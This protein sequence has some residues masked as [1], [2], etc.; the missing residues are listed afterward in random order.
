MADCLAVKNFVRLRCEK[1]SLWREFQVQHSVMGLRD[2]RSW[3][4]CL[5]PPRHFVHI[6]Q[7]GGA[8]VQPC[9]INCLRFSLDA[10]AAP[11][12]SR[13][14]WLWR[15]SLFHMNRSSMPTPGTVR[16]MARARLP[17]LV[18][19]H[20]IS[21]PVV[22]DAR[23]SSSRRS[24]S[25]PLEHVQAVRAAALVV[26]HRLIRVLLAAPAAHRDSVDRPASRYVPEVR[27]FVLPFAPCR[28]SG[29]PALSSWT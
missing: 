9:P 27:P 4:A 22:T 3:S 25:C 23:L 12:G 5:Q 26:I 24:S 2:C 13:Y 19:V 20:R 11:K 6:P 8:S 1:S 7:C 21:S 28:S 15:S 18:N 14:T 10:A 17:A 16:P 29:H